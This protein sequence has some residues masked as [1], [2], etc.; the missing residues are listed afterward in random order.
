MGVLCFLQVQGEG[1]KVGMKNLS[2]DDDDQLPGLAANF[3]FGI[4][5]QCSQ[6]NECNVSAA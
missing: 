4:N 5:E 6:Y 1:M 3:D 2:W